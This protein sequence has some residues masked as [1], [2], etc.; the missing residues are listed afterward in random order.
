MSMWDKRMWEKHYCDC[1][2]PELSD[3][4]EFGYRICFKCGLI[5]LNPAADVRLHGQIIRDEY[6]KKY[7]E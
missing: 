1:K 6:R 2:E 5:P 3:P 4:D 7:G